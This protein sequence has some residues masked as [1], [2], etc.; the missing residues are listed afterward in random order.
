MIGTTKAITPILDKPLTGNVYLVTEGNPL[1]DIVAALR[2]QINIDLKGKV[3]TFHSALRTTF[4]TVPDA[5]VTSFNLNLAGAGKGLI[6]NNTDI[7]KHL[8]PAVVQLDGQN[9][10]NANQNVQLGTPCGKARHKRH[11]RHLN[12]TRA[13][14]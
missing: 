5:P 3:S 12:R 4:T 14:R 6:V 7:C 8:G 10:K 9:G 13:V 1:P 2:G 11:R